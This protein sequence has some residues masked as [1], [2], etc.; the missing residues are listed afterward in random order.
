MSANQLKLKGKLAK[1]RVQPTPSV[2]EVNLG[3]SKVKHFKSDPGRTQK[4]SQSHE[5]NWVRLWSDTK[6]YTETMQ[7]FKFNLD[8]TRNLAHLVA[9]LAFNLQLNSLQGKLLW[10]ATF[11]N[12]KNVTTLSHQKCLSLAFLKG[13]STLFQKNGNTSGTWHMIYLDKI[14]LEK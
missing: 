1:I 7:L 3:L 2:G 10:C 11:W 9:L 8:R 13:F 5:T 12:S 14:K 6:C 4:V